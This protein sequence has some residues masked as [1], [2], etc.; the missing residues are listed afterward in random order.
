MVNC[1]GNSYCVESCYA[2]R[3]GYRFIL[4]GAQE[5]PQAPANAFDM[6][7]VNPIAGMMMQGYLQQ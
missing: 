5:Q 6:G 7:P 3:F 4:I 1:L 2:T